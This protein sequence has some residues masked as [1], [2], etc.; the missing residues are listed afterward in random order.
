MLGSTLI[1]AIAGFLVG[2]IA[3]ITFDGFA[4]S[5]ARPA[6]LVV[7]GK[8]HDREAF[9]KGY[10]AK[11]API[12]EKYGG[13]YLAVGRNHEVLEGEG[14]FES[15]VISRWPSMAAARTFWTSEEYAPLRQARI[16]NNW[17]TFDVFLLEG[18]PSTT[19]GP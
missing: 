6:Y 3:F 16:E 7:L 9:A 19:Q 12:Y 5:S 15:Y 14:A 17:G 11:L 4:Q 18:L 1:G 8:V 10:V 2:G 13:E